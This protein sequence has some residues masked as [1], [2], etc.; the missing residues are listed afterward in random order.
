MSP[1]PMLSP[2]LNSLGRITSYWLKSQ[3]LR[4]IG[5][6]LTRRLSEFYHVFRN[7][8]GTR[9]NVGDFHVLRHFNSLSPSSSPDSACVGPPVESHLRFP[10]R[11]ERATKSRMSHSGGRGVQ[12]APWSAQAKVPIFKRIIERVKRN[13]WSGAL[14]VEGT[15]GPAKGNPKLATPHRR[16]K[17]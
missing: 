14:P 15:D 7:T 11:E 16:N 10:E 6:I 17:K 1:G 5:G 3:S 9:M 4:K 2:V 13:G 12:A 8:R